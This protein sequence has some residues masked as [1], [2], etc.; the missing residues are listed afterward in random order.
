MNPPHT[1][2]II[3]ALR[4]LAVPIDS[5][6]PQKVNPRLG[7]VPVLQG[8][9]RLF[10]QRKAATAR[11][12][13]ELTSNSHLWRAAKAEG[14]THFAVAVVQEDEDPELARAW[15]LTENRSHD[16]GSYDQTLLEDE[17]EALARTAPQLLAEAFDVDAIV[18]DL[19]LDA[20]DLDEVSEPQQPPS[21]G[22]TPGRKRPDPGDVVPDTRPGGDDDDAAPA[23]AA[24][25]GVDT[26]GD[27]DPVTDMDNPGAGLG[28]TPG[29]TR[30]AAPADVDTT[31]DTDDDGPVLFHVGDLRALV[32][33]DAWTRWRADLM[34]GCEGDR[35]QAGRSA[36]VMLGLPPDAV[37][38][39]PEPLRPPSSR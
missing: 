9:L 5:V 19:H 14:M 16:V 37:Q 35:G 27:S 21:R 11:P 24:P 10:G 33:R 13:G 36:A 8:S 23:A 29:G 20:L 6:R 26:P 2:Q 39:F 31:A 22:F 30:A 7:D 1:P 3:P 17:L 25:Q 32:D 34:E 12:D 15:S 38:L 28:A 4:T 18:A